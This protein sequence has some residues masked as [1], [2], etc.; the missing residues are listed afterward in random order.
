[1]GIIPYFPLIIWHGSIVNTQITITLKL[2]DLMGVKTLVG[3]GGLQFTLKDF[4]QTIDHHLVSIRLCKP[5]CMQFYLVHT[6]T[7]NL[8][9]FPVQVLNRST[10]FLGI[11]ITAAVFASGVS[12]PIRLANH[13]I[14]SFNADFRCIRLPQDKVLQLLNN[15]RREGRDDY[16]ICLP[17]IGAGIEGDGKWIESDA[18]INTKPNKLV[19]AGL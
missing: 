14:D 6:G 11:V 1:M 8:G 12:F 10:G 19:S 16:A 7:V 13:H 2:P 4:L 3:I 17:D 18:G 5:P 15:I 9:G